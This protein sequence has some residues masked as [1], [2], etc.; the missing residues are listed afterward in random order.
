[1]ALRRA[2]PSICLAVVLAFAVSAC[3]D[4]S[5]GAD[6][7][8]DDDDDD[9]VDAAPYGDPDIEGEVGTWTWLPVAGTQCMD[10]SPTGLGVNLAESSGDVL[11]LMEGGGAC[12]NAFTCAGVAHPDGYDAGDLADTAEQLGGRGIFDRTDEDNPFRNYHFIFLPYCTGDIF[13]GSNPE[14]FGGRAQV[15]YDNVTAYLDVLVPAFRES[16]HVVLAGVSAGG[17]GALWNYHRT[18][19]AFADLRVTLLDDSGP[20]LSDDYLSPCLQQQLRDTW[21]LDATLP[22]DCADCS[23]DDG[24]GLGNAVT[25]L[26]DAHPDERLGLVASTRDGVIRLF[27]GYGY[28]SCENPQVPMPEEPYAEGIAELRD[29]TLAGHDNFR[30]FTVDSGL[31]TWLF[32]SPVGG[33][34]VGGVSLTSW[35]RQHLSEDG[36]FASVTPP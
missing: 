26:A 32:E 6:G 21:N 34:T 31:H 25:Y 22:P 3:G 12:F 13:A 15:G 35:L 24:G 2:V 17:F 5:S 14:G 9:D 29:V 19:E 20:P 7:G 10:G 16:N 30:V 36:D 8:G 28:P 18:V 1:M 11:I 33:T 23:S 4:S 27:Y